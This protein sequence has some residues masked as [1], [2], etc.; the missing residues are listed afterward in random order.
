MYLS[1]YPKISIVTP[2]FNQG[3]FLEQTIMSVLGQN[4]P[5]LEYIIIDGGSI[6]N[7]VEIIK[8]YENKLAYWESRKDQGQTHAINK[9]LRRATGD[10]IAYLNSDDQYCPGVLYIAADHFLNHSQSM[11]LCG[12]VLYADSEG[13]VSTK[14]KPIYSP[15]ILRFASSSLYQPNVFLR[16]QILSEVGYLRE[17]FHTIMDQEWFCRIAEFYPPDIVDIDFAKFRWH[18]NSKSSSGRETAYYQR[19]LAEKMIIFSRYLP[20]LMP[21]IERVPE[22]TLFSFNLIGRG[23]KLWVRIKHTVKMISR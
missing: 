5:N 7:S 4:Y 22:A 16:R 18:P 15:F 20:A 3:Q 6:D 21:V 23:L 10:I 19:Y 8:K 13:T 11:W 1:S 17:D 9:G 14:K 12:N 2:S